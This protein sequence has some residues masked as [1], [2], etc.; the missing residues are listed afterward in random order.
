MEKKVIELE[1]ISDFFDII[2]EKINNFKFIIGIFFIVELIIDEFL[3]RFCEFSFRNF[4]EFILMKCKVLI[5]EF[6]KKL[7]RKGNFEFNKFK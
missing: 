2:M 6:C 7:K 1:G 5:M 4:Y 3:E